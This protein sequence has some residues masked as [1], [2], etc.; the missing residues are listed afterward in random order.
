MLTVLR[1]IEGAAVW[2]ACAALLAMGSIVT[3]SVIGRVAFNMPVPDD[4]IMVGLLM[5]CVIIL[6]LAWVERTDGHISVTVIADLLPV[7]VQ[8][9]LRVLGTVLFAGF[10]G[11]MGYMLAL[12]VP[13]EYAE[14]LYYDGQLYIP[15][16]PMKAVFV[17]GV[18]VLVARCLVS[19][20]I[21]TRAVISGRAPDVPDDR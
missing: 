3:A 7:R 11:T 8:Y 19:L 13:G 15:T 18:A 17:F 2:L 9:A 6:P 20:W 21:N 4:L 5:V 14:N 1:K 10:F 12:K 16:W